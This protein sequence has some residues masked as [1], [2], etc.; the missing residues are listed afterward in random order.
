MRWGETSL[1]APYICSPVLSL[2]KDFP[3]L[4]STPATAGMEVGAHTVCPPNLSF[5]ESRDT[6]PKPASPILP[7]YNR[8]VNFF[9]RDV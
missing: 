6:H 7:V 1:H 4:Y 3:V 2:I 9:V 5:L 8:G